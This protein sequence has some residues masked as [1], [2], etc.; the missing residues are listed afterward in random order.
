M[1]ACVWL[2]LAWRMAISTIRALDFFQRS[3]AFGNVE[4]GQH[5]AVGKLPGRRRLPATLRLEGRQAAARG[6]GHRERQILGAQIASSSRIM[7]R[8][9]AFFSSRTLPGQL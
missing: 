8:S 2:P 6:L 7:A 5:A 1:A 4:L 9:I 3:S